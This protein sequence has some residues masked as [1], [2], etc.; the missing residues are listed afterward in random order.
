MMSACLRD[1]NLNS[2][3]YFDRKRLLI[4][5]YGKPVVHKFHEVSVS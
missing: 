4:V 5:V 1:R 3:E 2:I